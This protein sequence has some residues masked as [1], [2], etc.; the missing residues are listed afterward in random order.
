MTMEWVDTEYT[1]KRSDGAKVGGFWI[2][3]KLEWWAYPS[4]YSL[5]ANN[6][7]G[8]FKTMNEA[9]DILDGCVRI[10]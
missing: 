8:P 2:S 7:L 10:I 5:R 1:S 9:K 6:A 4:D 3:G